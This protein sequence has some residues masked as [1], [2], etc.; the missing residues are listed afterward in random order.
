MISRKAI[1]H[2]K[3]AIFL[4]DLEAQSDYEAISKM[5]GLLRAHPDVRNFEEFSADV[6]DRQQT[7]PPLFPGGVAFPHA[8]TD[9][10]KALVMVVSTC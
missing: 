5:L 3:D 8:R 2:L 4:K 10:V 1:E 9:A 7:D 6:F